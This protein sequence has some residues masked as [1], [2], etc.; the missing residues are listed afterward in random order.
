MH[1]AVD[2]SLPLPVYEQLRSQLQ[3]LIIS[4]QLPVGARLP[5]I[6]QMAKDLGLA[7]ATV[8]RVYDLLASDG[9]VVAAGRNGTVVNRAARSTELR[10]EMSDATEHLALLASQLGVDRD[11]IL[12]LLDD[13]LAAQ[14]ERGQPI[15][16]AG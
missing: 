5:T 13:A 3:R 12:R 6:R 15:G 2:T 7:S 10:R 4:G 16:S 8:S 11:E 14:S 1:V 9:W